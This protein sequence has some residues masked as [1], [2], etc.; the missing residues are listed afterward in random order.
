MNRSN[1]AA[2]MAILL[3]GISAVGQESPNPLPKGTVGF[4]R[5]NAQALAASPVLAQYLQIFGASD[6]QVADEFLKRLPVEPSSAISLTGILWQPQPRREPFAVLLA[7]FKDPVDLAKVA[8][9]LGTRAPVKTPAGELTIGGGV[10]ILARSPKGLVMGNPEMVQAFA[11]A[12]PLQNPGW[13]SAWDSSADG[14]ASAWLTTDLRALPAEV[15]G[16][17]KRTAWMYLQPLQ[18]SITA[19]I[20]FSMDKRLAVARATVVYGN[21]GAAKASV[22]NWKL[23]TELIRGFFKGGEGIVTL[24]PLA[25]SVLDSSAVRELFGTSNIEGAEL[26][27]SPMVTAAFAYLAGYLSEQ[28]EFLAKLPFE[29]NGNSV[30]VSVKVSPAAMQSGIGVSAVLAGLMLPAVQSTREA[31]RRMQSVNNLK[32][33]GIALHGYHD[34]YGDFPPAVVRDKDGKPLYSWRVLILPYL[35]Q[36]NIFSKWK[37]DEP[38]DSPNNKPL[39]DLVLKVY[40]ASGSPD[41]N[42]NRTPYRVFMGK[43]SGFEENKARPGKGLRFADFTDGSSNTIAVVEASESVPWAKPDEL[44]FVAGKPLPALGLP[45]R[46]GFNALYFDGSVRSIRKAVNP[47][48]LQ[49]LITRNGGEVVPFDP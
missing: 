16:G 25:A 36:E 17:I 29:A 49:A 42:T 3:I 39:S 30:S 41:E 24:A 2:M 1:L 45:G 19:G 20:S 35:E 22:E 10:A 18:G 31:A 23:T 6:K 26:L 5:V 44:E 21:E 46:D 15:E 13:K 48:T 28:A 37:R 33:I 40:S 12:P 9:A 14:I 47:Q 34:L 32:Q 8:R 7:D 38:W 4:F 11:S 43:G 27:R